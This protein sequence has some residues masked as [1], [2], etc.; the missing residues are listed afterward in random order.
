MNDVVK[1]L[2]DFALANYEEGG[3]WVYECWGNEDYLQALTEGG[4]L[5]GAMKVI[6]DH[7]EMTCALNRECAWG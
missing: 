3:H 4:D 7:W 2:K 1:V 6:K 5:A